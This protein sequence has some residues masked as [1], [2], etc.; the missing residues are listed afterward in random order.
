MLELVLAL[1]AADVKS[2]LR[3]HSR[4]GFPGDRRALSAEV[5][6]GSPH[7]RQQRPATRTVLEPL[8]RVSARSISW[9]GFAE[10][11]R[12]TLEHWRF[13]KAMHPEKHAKRR[14]LHKSAL[15]VWVVWSVLWI[16]VII[17]NGAPTGPMG[18]AIFGFFVLSASWLGTRQQG[19]MK[20]WERHKTGA[21]DLEALE[22][23]A[24]EFE[25]L[26]AEAAEL[27]RKGGSRLRGPLRSRQG[28]V[29]AR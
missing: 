7:A 15:I 3:R 26:E 28:T 29:K 18:I 4:Q 5:A 12:A 17:V 10:H 1:V 8:N 9:T 27:G 19:R 22:A 13:A 20:D 21:Q 25:A 24:R 23:E 2:C 6:T 14:Q 16:A 11:W